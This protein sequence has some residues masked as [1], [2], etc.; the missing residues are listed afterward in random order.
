[1]SEGEK[2]QRTQSTLV[3][4]ELELHTM[5]GLLGRALNG[6]GSVVGIVGPPG[7]GKSRLVREAMSIAKSRGVN[8]FSTYCESHASQ[9]PFHSIA[10][11]FRA[12]ARITGLDDADARAQLRAQLPDADHDDL[13]LLDDLLGVA[14]PTM[15][16]PRIDPD[17]R[18][19]R[20]G[21]LINTANLA[22]TEP[23]LY[24]MEDVHWIDQGSESM[25]TDILAVIGQTPARRVAR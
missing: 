25:M 8:V 1:A 20:L 6:R 14:D 10:R 4:R 15:T 16:L 22:R 18:R 9:I 13:L 23:I 12:A 19:R 7:I 24:V 11:L 5:S 3:G 21:A 17:A 2:A